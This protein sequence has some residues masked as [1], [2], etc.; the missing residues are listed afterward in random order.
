MLHF[1]RIMVITS[2]E[3]V[4]TV[5][6]SLLEAEGHHVVCVPD[7]QQAL[8]SLQEEPTCHAILF[9]TSLHVP[10]SLDT[11]E[12]LAKQYGP[13]RLWL[14]ASL[15]TDLWEA[16]A[17]RLGIQQILRKPLQR[18]DLEHMLNAVS[19][20]RGPSHSL[21]GHAPY[22]LEKLECGRYFL[23]GCQAM[24]KIY[25]TVRLLAPV[26]VPVLILGESGVGKDVVANLLHRH[27]RRSHESYI[28]V[29]C[30]ALPADLLE[31]ELFGYE[32]GAFTGAVKAKPGKF[33]MANRGTILLDEIGEMSAPMQAKLLHV[34]HDGYFSRL[35]ARASTRVDVR[36]AAATNINI[37]D[38]MA[39]NM[40]REDLY[41]RISAFTIT[42]PPL[43]ERR[44]E[45]P[46]FIEEMLRRHAENFRQRSV[47]VSPQ[48][49]EM[50]QEYDW[51]G[52][53][54]ELSNFVIR[55]LIL[56]DPNAILSD[57]TAKIRSKRGGAK[58]FRT[59]LELGAESE[60]MHKIVRD[61][62]N[63]TESRLIQE[64][65]DAAGWNRRR[66]AMQLRISYRTLLYKIQQY[67]LKN[68]AV[69]YPAVATTGTK[70]GAASDCPLSDQLLALNKSGL[71][72]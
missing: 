44:E 50:L 41:Y 66:A 16:N 63:Q 52:N 72:P 53:L 28:S 22:Y 31:S 21:P 67:R 59:T 6:K 48:L 19:F 30:A 43:R 7:P 69:R 54:R 23:A 40:F 56:Q 12:A 36:V 26:D 8:C 20:S 9:D 11:L 14:V 4:A 64:A 15:G 49:M 1:L 38:A 25:E 39:N 34:L 68:T 33:E 46:F 18:H 61:F 60:N 35:G 29:N 27:S 42:I 51:P 55:M 2:D 58:G 70:R 13:E 37:E 71:C 3:S 24:K 62:K 57:L 65:L 45:I 10:S 47:Y 5:T 17:K 32:T